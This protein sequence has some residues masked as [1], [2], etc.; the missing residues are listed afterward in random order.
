MED[1]VI[2]NDNGM[3][4]PTIEREFGM[5]KKYLIW[6]EA[7]RYRIGVPETRLTGDSVQFNGRSNIGIANLAM[8]FGFA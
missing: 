6:G 4:S 3:P 2:D 7:R 1:I 5:M 8:F